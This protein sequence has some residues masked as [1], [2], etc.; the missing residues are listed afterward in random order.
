MLNV[1]KES[2]LWP[3]KQILFLNAASRRFQLKNRDD[4]V[5]WADDQEFNLWVLNS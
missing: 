4:R 3:Q 5:I 1:K 2:R